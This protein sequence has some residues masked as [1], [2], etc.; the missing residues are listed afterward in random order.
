MVLVVGLNYLKNRRA[1]IIN[2]ANHRLDWISHFRRRKII[3]IITYVNSIANKCLLQRF[4]NR[5]WN[6]IMKLPK[7][8]C[9]IIMSLMDDLQLWGRFR[10]WFI[11]IYST[12]TNETHRTDRVHD[13]DNI[14]HVH[15]LCRTL[16]CVDNFE[17]IFCYFCNVS[18]CCTLSC[19]CC[20]CDD[21]LNLIR[22]QLYWHDS[23]FV[24]AIEWQ[25]NDIQMEK[26]I[27]CLNMAGAHQCGMLF[28]AR[29]LIV[30]AE[31]WTSIM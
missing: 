21:S 30:R 6:A 17:Q 9:K 15:F 18:R 1:A 28:T 12:T 13:A 3:N 24:I 2:F 20:L 26:A 4:S 8:I 29:K 23:L 27:K 25:S 19:L 22:C 31:R 16:N 10:K 5:K 11:A 7:L 14:L